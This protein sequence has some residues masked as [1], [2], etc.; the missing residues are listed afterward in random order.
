[1]VSSA[2]KELLKPNSQRKRLDKKLPLSNH[3]HGQVQDLDDP[4]LET[5]RPP[6]L[7]D[8]RTRIMEAKPPAQEKDR[9]PLNLN[10]SSLSE[11]MMSLAEQVHRALRRRQRPRALPPSA[12]KKRRTLDAAILGRRRQVPHRNS[13]QKF[14]LA[15]ES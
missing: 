9:I 8:Q 2:L 6:N 3:S 12:V 10:Q 14:R 1:M 15:Y 5:F 7:C 4:A 11:K 13:Y